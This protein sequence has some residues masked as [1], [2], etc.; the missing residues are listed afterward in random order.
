MDQLNFTFV[1]DSRRMRQGHRI[2]YCSDQVGR[3][4]GPD[5]NRLSRNW[6]CTDRLDRRRHPL[7][8]IGFSVD[9]SLK[10]SNVPFQVEMHVVKG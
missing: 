3:T 9:A 4:E 6:E 2:D 5:Y 8:K 1:H 7:M 10:I